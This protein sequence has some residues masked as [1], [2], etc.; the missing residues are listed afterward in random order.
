MDDWDEWDEDDDMDT[1]GD[2]FDKSFFRGAFTSR[3]APVQASVRGNVRVHNSSAKMSWNW[4]DDVIEPVSPEPS[5]DN[6]RV[7]ICNNCGNMDNFVKQI[8]CELCC[9]EMELCVICSEKGIEFC[10][11]DCIGKV[12]VKAEFSGYSVVGKM[13]LMKRVLRG[14]GEEADV[15]FVCER[16][17][18]KSVSSD[19]LMD[20]LKKNKE[21]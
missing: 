12:V 3:V 9:K 11:D 21:I 6:Y 8:E 7:I 18:G 17:D 20:Y 10:C 19:L 16:E 2:K 1:F 5:R 4:F 14:I 13:K 15:I